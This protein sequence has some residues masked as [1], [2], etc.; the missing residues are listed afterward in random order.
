MRPLDRLVKEIGQVVARA[1][2][3][4]RI[5]AGVEPLL[6]QALTRPELLAPAQRQ[7]TVE[8]YQQHVLHVAADRSFS[9]VSLVWTPGQ[10]TPVHD[11][12]GWCVVG[13]YEGEEFETA[14]RV[15]DDGGR[16]LLQECGTRTHRRGETTSLVPPIDI[17]RVQNRSDA[18]A[19]SVHVYGVD[20]E[21]AGSS[22]ARRFAL[23]AESHR[24]D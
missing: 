20:V 24:E 16:P 22:I 18:L 2:S 8:S 14:Y 12:L 5:A 1:T 23:H 4:S 3:P 17:H 13:V 19:V 9:I 15:R 7:V 21:R 10:E 6:K 11:H